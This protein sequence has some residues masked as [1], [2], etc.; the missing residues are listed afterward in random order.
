MHS[1]KIRPEQPP[2][3]N[4]QI[5][6]RA[7]TLSWSNLCSETHSFRNAIR[8]FFR[9]NVPNLARHFFLQE[10]LHES[11]H[12]LEI[13]CSSANLDRNFCSPWDR[14]LFWAFFLPPGSTSS[15]SKNKSFNSSFSVL[16]QD[17]APRAS[18]PSSLKASTGGNR[19]MRSAH[20]TRNDRAAEHGRTSQ[21]FRLRSKGD[22]KHIGFCHFCATISARPGIITH[23]ETVGSHRILAPIVATCVELAGHVHTLRLDY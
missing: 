19:G 9:S 11:R 18:D 13:T 22:S 4:L 12:N 15:M 20:A 16:T 8:A 14:F 5:P 3:R 2:F 1:G 17:T 6:R 23:S 7:S 10:T 21:G